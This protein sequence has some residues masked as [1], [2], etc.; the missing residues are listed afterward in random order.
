M[1]TIVC[2]YDGSDPCRAALAQAAEIATAMDD[3]LVVVFGFA[4]SRLGGEVPDYAKALHERADT[5]EKLARD[6]A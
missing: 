1:G 6:Q 5:V 4:V 2:G 3:R